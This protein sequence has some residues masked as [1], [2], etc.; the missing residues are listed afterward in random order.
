M[1]RARKENQCRKCPLGKDVLEVLLAIDLLR[2]AERIVD[3]IRELRLTLRREN[4]IHLPL[5]RV[6]DESTLASRSVRFLVCGTEVAGISVGNL[7]VPAMV[8]AC[9]RCIAL[10]RFPEKAP[11]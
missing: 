9:L 10:K 7:D 6:R 8:V 3:S 5:V 4:K 2:E 11:A 1:K